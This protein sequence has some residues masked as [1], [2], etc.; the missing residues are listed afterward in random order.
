MRE[1]DIHHMH[2]TRREHNKQTV[3]KNI[4]NHELSKIEMYVPV[5][6]EL[7]Q[8]VQPIQ[9]L[10]PAIGRTALILLNELD[11][12]YRPLDAAKA[13]Y[14]EL[15]DTDAHEIAEHL[16]RQIPFF[17]LSARALKRRVL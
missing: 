6:R 16:G 11:D 15:Y 10:A 3:A 17:E 13:L 2:F 8:Y 7:H 5:H 1:T 14:D 9:P 12:R 4:R